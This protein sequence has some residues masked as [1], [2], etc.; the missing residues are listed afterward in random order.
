MVQLPG[1]AP[2]QGEVQPDLGASLH[3]LSATVGLATRGDGHGGPDSRRVERALFPR[4]GLMRPGLLVALLGFTLFAPLHA[5]QAGP[6]A[7]RKEQITVPVF[8]KV[9]V[10]RPEQVQRIRGVIL[11]VSGDGG[12]NLGVIEMARRAAKDSLVV[13][14]S[15]PAWRKQVEHH[16]DL[17]WFPAGDLESTAQTIEKTYK[18]P[19]YIHPILMGYSSGATAV[20]AAI[21]QAPT[22][23]CAR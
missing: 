23:A 18:L 12:W 5:M 17:C 6:A 14:L 13:G 11:F 4:G 19:R 21:A 22:D 10:Y 7:I 15:M 8:G 9:T 20:Y 2:I 16:P 1:A 3:G